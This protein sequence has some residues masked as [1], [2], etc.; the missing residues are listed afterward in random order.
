VTREYVTLEDWNRLNP[1][2]EREYTPKELAEIAK[3]KAEVD[4]MKD[5]EIVPDPQG[6]ERLGKTATNIVAYVGHRRGRT[7]GSANY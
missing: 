6:G 5:A 1:P 4:A 2:R 3:R 7:A